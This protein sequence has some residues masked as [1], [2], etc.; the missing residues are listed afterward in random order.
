L[1]K[2]MK[3]KAK[4]SAHT[5]KVLEEVI[6]SVTKAPPKDFRMC[7]W[8][9]KKDECGTTACAWG[10]WMRDH[11]RRRVVHEFW[12]NYHSLLHDE[13]RTLTEYLNIPRAATE[14]LFSMMSYLPIEPR[15]RTVIARIKRFIRTNGKSAE[16]SS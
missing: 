14:H 10:W 11:P 5:V 2:Q 16:A 6:E 9:E 15:R 13:W 12:E 7:S 8:D 4:L 1:E 3:D